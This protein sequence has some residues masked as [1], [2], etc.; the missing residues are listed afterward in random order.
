MGDAAGSSVMA[1][2]AAMVHGTAA[3]WLVWLV[4]RGGF[5]R[6]RVYGFTHSE[7]FAWASM[8][9][10]GGGV[11]TILSLRSLWLC[12]CRRR[13]RERERQRRLAGAACSSRRVYSG[14]TI[15]PPRRAER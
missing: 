2:A 8:E 13:E 6:G 4:R 1:A 11:L 9:G 3:V 15:A 7:Q 14:M 5:G 12:L 10:A